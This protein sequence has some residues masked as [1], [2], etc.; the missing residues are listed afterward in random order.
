M[1]KGGA[2]ERGPCSDKPS[3][4]AIYKSVVERV[5]QPPVALPQPPSC[6]QP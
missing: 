2:D 3:V 4:E 6:E 5:D 1:W